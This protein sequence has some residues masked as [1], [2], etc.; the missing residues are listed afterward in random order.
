MLVTNDDAKGY[1]YGWE[2]E[3]LVEYF[4]YTWLEVL[5]GNHCLEIGSNQTEG[6]VYFN[7]I[8]VKKSDISECYNH[9]DPIDTQVQPDTDYINNDKDQNENKYTAV[10]KTNADQVIEIDKCSENIIISHRMLSDNDQTEN[11][12]LVV[13]KNKYKSHYL[14]HMNEDSGIDSDQSEDIDY[15]NHVLVNSS[16]V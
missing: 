9:I 15:I 13:D 10:K 5:G 11:I 6:I 12:T 7:H 16:N 4:H 3:A 2:F 8:S 14:S 1:E